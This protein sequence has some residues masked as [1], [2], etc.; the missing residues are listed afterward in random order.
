M[1]WMFCF[2]SLIVSPPSSPHFVVT[3]FGILICKNLIFLL[4]WI[5]CF[6]ANEENI[7]LMVNSPTSRSHTMIMSNMIALFIMYIPL[8][9][10]CVLF[11]CKYKQYTQKCNFL[12]LFCVILCYFSAKNGKML[13]DM[14][15]CGQLLL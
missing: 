9:K 13:Y 4:W 10:D 11:P 7:L 5:L 1:I 15:C 2:I 12:I 3:L 14:F 6:L 8:V